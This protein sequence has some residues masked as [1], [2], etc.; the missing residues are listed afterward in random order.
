MLNDLIFS[1]GI[2]TFNRNQDLFR[3]LDSLSKQTYKDFSIVIAN[4]G[5]VQG[6]ERVVRNFKDLKIKIVTQ[7]RKG[8]VEAR[9]LGWRHSEADV[10]CLI[11]DDLVVYPDWLAQVRETFLADS[12]IGGVSGPTL[13]PKDRQANRDLAL[14]LNKFRNSRNIF[15]TPLRKVYLGII[16][17]N[18]FAEVGRILKSGAFTPGSNYE[19]CLKL[20]G[21]V[22][23]DYLEACYMCFR[24]QL[25]EDLNGFDYSYSGTGEWNEPDFSFRVRK[26]GFRLV[27]N[28]KAISEHHIS[29]SGVY[30][31]RTNSY[32]RSLNFLLFYFRWI[33]P[34]TWEKFFRFSVN[35]IFINLYW[36]YKFIESGNINWLDGIRGTAV[37]LTQWGLGERKFRT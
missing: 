37:G 13:I 32:E 31:A 36:V 5:D 26:R 2:S 19:S 1:I 27:F 17:E 20:P 3:C 11:D 12:S 34:D 15:L 21:L 8:I 4:G 29:Q 23:V 18:K 28:P 24:R 10:V 22:E 25:L 14:F 9:N 16:L 33:K 6:V 35:L 30:K 7:A